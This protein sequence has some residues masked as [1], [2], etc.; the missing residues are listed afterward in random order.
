M[1][2]GFLAK[3]QSYLQR[4]REGSMATTLTVHLWRGGSDLGVLEDIV[5]AT[6]SEVIDTNNTIYVDVQRQDFICPIASYDALASGEPEAG[7][8]IVVTNASDDGV[9]YTLTSFG[10][11]PA[12]EPHDP[13]AGTAY[14]L[15]TEIASVA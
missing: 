10:G 14:R 2:K 15:H 8:E 6:A 3:G 13:E 7:D 9:T 5:F 12:W 1:A 11:Q 4:V